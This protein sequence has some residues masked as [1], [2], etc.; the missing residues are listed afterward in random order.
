MRSH[1]VEHS[2]ERLP[3]D[4]EM[5]Y[6]VVNFMNMLV[7]G[8]SN[9][10]QQRINFICLDN[11]CLLKPW[12]E[13]SH[14]FFPSLISPFVNS[15]RPSDPTNSK[16]SVN[17]W[18]IEVAKAE[19]PNTPIKIA[20]YLMK[21][22]KKIVEDY[23]MEVGEAQKC[24]NCN[25]DGET[26]RTFIFLPTSFISL[27]D[28]GELKRYARKECGEN[29]DKCEF[30]HFNYTVDTVVDMAIPLESIRA[31][32]ERLANTTCFFLRER[33]A[34]PVLGIGKV[35]IQ[36]HDGSSFI[37]EDVKYVPG[38]R[39]SLISL[40]TLEKEGYMVKM[41]M[42]RIKVAQIRLEDK[43]LEEKMNTNCLVKEQEKKKVEESIK[44]NLGKLLKY[45]AW[46][47]R[48]DVSFSLSMVIRHQQNTG[49]GHWTTVK[50]ILKYLRIT[51]DMFLVYGREEEI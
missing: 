30:L 41:Q 8:S 36:L 37:L 46:S 13:Y 51:K 21:P 45:N 35:K 28:T 31:I 18:S 17:A 2:W 43:Q 27:A 6:Q 7:F 19:D 40:G 29:N 23:R 26:L 34:Y 20:N 10:N 49:D 48:S 14:I 5:A 9:Q 4:C 11:K 50:N 42:G 12:E 1:D 32:S 25:E 47:T 22:S 33:M 15:E 44:A 16:M 38:L 3:N 39:R 24:C